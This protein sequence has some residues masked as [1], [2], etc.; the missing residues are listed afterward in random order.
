MSTSDQRKLLK[1]LGGYTVAAGSVGAA[2]VLTLAIPP[3]RHKAP[4]LLL[5]LGVMVSARWG[6]GKGL[7]ATALGAAMAA[8]FLISPH[9]SFS[10]SGPE[11]LVP[12]ILFCSVG[13]A[14]T[15]IT[16]RLHISRDS[17]VAANRTLAEAQRRTNTILESISDGFSAFDRGWRYVYVNAAGARMMGETS[18]QLLGKNVWELWPQ[19]ADSP[20]GAACR[21]AMSESVPVEVE[22]LYLEPFKRWYQVRCYPSPD[23]LSVFSSDVTERKQAE[24]SVR[25]EQE[26]LRR[27]QKAESIGMLAGGI[28][29]DFN[30]LLVGVL[31]NASLAQ[32]VLPPD[33]PAA[34]LLDG[35][36]KAGERAAHLTRQMLAYA[37]KGRFMLEPLNLSDL[38]EDMIG[39]VQPSIS[40]K[41]ALR[42]EFEPDLPS[43]E[44]DRS[45]MQQVFMNLVINAAEAV[46]S[47][48]GLVSITTGVEDVDDDPSRRQLEAPELVPGKYVYLQVRD[49]GCGMD[50]ATK[51]RIFDPFFST[52]FQG[53]GLGLAAVS[54]IVRGHQGAIKV[55]SAPGEGSCFTVLF[56]TVEGAAAALPVAGRD[57]TLHGTGTILVVD[58]EELVRGMAKKALELYGYKVLQ[59]DS[60]LAAIDAF[61]RHPSDI[62]LV[63][64][65]LSMPGM[66]G[67]EALPELRKIR[68]SVK[69]MVLSGYSEEEMMRV[70]DGQQ[71]AGFL[72][73]PFTS[74]LLA[75][76]LKNVLG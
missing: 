35:V 46:G 20:F 75:E 27:A 40:K 10:L 3:A 59:A 19:A 65:D 36:I 25:K 51:S 60:G 72:Q 32:D 2:L 74:T 56:P 37:G 21:R 17:L 31:G 29:H 24:E 41:I 43:I 47:D 12:L 22:A 26:N 14:I 58:D 53:R 1:T 69:I 18:E 30:N 11:D 16:H 33:N 66:G 7:F 4:Y 49:S 64:L 34:D 52:K 48:T 71:V 57:G 28:A 54:G 8:Y 76:K 68:P 5:T 42:L 73:K 23:G 70:F 63:M 67:E 6:L 50:E 9:H 44:A 38:C 62:S 39:L 55:S 15:S 45:Q 61:K 13:V